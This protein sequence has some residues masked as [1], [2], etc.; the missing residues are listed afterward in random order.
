MKNPFV[1]GWQH[2]FDPFSN[3]TRVTRY[4]HSDFELFAHCTPPEFYEIAIPDDS[5]DYSDH[6]CHQV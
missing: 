6:H 3:I 1:I 5:D 4:S 2:F